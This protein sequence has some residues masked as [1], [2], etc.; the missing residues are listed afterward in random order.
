MKAATV[1]HETAELAAS[2]LVHPIRVVT[3]AARTDR[4]ANRRVNEDAMLV[5]APLLAVA[6]GVGGHR[7]GEDASTTALDVLRREIRVLAD[8]PEEEL[9]AALQLANAEVRAAAEVPWRNGMAATVVVAL[10]GGATVTVAHVGDSRAYLFRAGRMRQITA[11]HSLVSS[12]VASGSLDADAARFHPMRSVILRA[13]GL[14]TSVQPDITTLPAYSDDVLLLCSD[15]LSDAVGVDELERMAQ[16]EPDLDHLV[17][18]MAG[19]ARHSGSGDDVTVV[20]ARL[21]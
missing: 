21:G 13:V 15:G 20:A 17:E 9:E 18:R 7:A 4:G 3:C 16:T 11:D 6:D 19:A 8:R 2:E 14:D 5:A 10:T 12:L 1:T